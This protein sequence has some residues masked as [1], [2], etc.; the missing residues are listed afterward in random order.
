MK[1]K[2][3]NP[4]FFTLCLLLLLTVPKG[5]S[6]LTATVYPSDD[7]AVSE[8]NGNSNFGS[9]QSAIVGRVASS[10][11]DWLTF[12]RF[13][14]S[15]IPSNANVSSA[16]LHL[17]GELVGNGLTIRAYPVTGSWSESSINWNNKPSI[18]T[19]A[20]EST[21]FSSD[22]SKS[23][24]FTSF[25]STWVSGTSSNY[26]IMLL[27]ESSSTNNYVGLGTSENNTSSRRPRLVVDYTASNTAPSISGFSG[28][29][30]S[31]GRLDF[32]YTATDSDGISYVGVY[33]VNSNQSVNSSFTLA[34]E[35]QYNSGLSSGVSRTLQP[36][37]A[38]QLQ[39][40]L[41]PGTQYRLRMKAEDPQGG[42][43]GWVYSSAF[44]Y[45]ASNT[46][47]SISGFSGNMR[48]DGRLD[49][50]YTATDSDGISYV[51][52]YI[53]NNDQSV[54][55]S[56]T[57]ASEKQYNSGLSSG[58][59]RTLQPWTASQLQGWLAPGTQYRLRMKA[60]DPLGGDTG[61]VY[62]SAFT[63]TASNTA[64]S[65]SGFSGSMRSDG[66]LDFNYTATDSDGISYVGVYIVN[67]DQ[68]VN[69]SF[70]L[71]SEKQY[72]SGL[73][74][75]VARTLQP[76]TASQLQGWLTPGTQYRLRM[77]A[78]DPLGGDTGWVYSSAFTYTA[79]NTSPAITSLSDVAQL[80]DGT[81]QLQFNANDPDGDSMHA[82]LAIQRMNG[83]YVAG[84]TPETYFATV[85]SGANTLQLTPA[86][87]LNM[88]DFP[89]GQYRIR[90]RVGDATHTSVSSQNPLLTNYFSYVPPYNGGPAYNTA[91]ISDNDIESYNS[92]SA[93]EIREFLQSKGSY[94]AVSVLDVD[95]V[96][97]DAASV[98]YQA[99]QSSQINPKVLLATLEKESQGVSGSTR[100]SETRLRNL[101]GC[102]G[103]STARAQLECAAVTFRSCFDR[104]TNTGSTISGWQ[105]G[106][107]KQTQDGVEV[108]PASK[109]VA[110]QF[111]Y[112][113]YAGLQW[114][115][116]TNFGGVY[117]F[118]YFWQQF[119]FGSGVVN[120]NTPTTPIGY[121]CADYIPGSYASRGFSPFGIGHLGE[122][123]A[124]LEGT[125]IYA[126]ASGVIKYYGAATGY[127]TL[128]VAIEHDLGEETSHSFSVGHSKTVTMRNY[129]S[130]YGHLRKNSL[131]WQVG[132]E[133]Q[134]GDII[135]Y[136]QNAATNGDGNEHLHFGLFVHEYRGV[137][138]GYYNAAIPLATETHWVSGKEF[139]DAF[140]SG[141]GIVDPDV[142]QT[143]DA[144]FA[145]NRTNPKV[146]SEITHPNALASHYEAR[147]MVRRIMENFLGRSLSNTELAAISTATPFNDPSV[148][149]D[150]VLRQEVLSMLV[151]GVETIMGYERPPLSPPLTIPDIPTSG[152][153]REAILGA[154]A[155]NLADESDLSDGKIYP[156][157]PVSRYRFAKWATGTMDVLLNP[158][159]SAPT[160]DMEA[161]NLTNPPVMS[162]LSAPRRYVSHY[163][164]RLMV[165]RTVEIALGREITDPVELAMIS[166][167]TPFGDP[168]IRTGEASR[169]EVFQM[170]LGGIEGIGQ[171]SR[172]IGNGT[173]NL[174]DLPSTG[175]QL[176][177]INGC[178][179]WSIFDVTDTPSS[180]I[181]ESARVSR[182]T[183]AKWDNR[184][185]S[186]LGIS[187]ASGYDQWI[188]QE[189]LSGPDAAVDADPDR[190]GIVNL[191]E[192]ASGTLANSSASVERSTI[193]AP[194]NG[195]IDFTFR[196]LSARTDL[197]YEVELFDA[198]ET[199]KTVARS[200]AGGV[201][202][203]LD[204]VVQSINDNQ[205]ASPLVIVKIDST[206]S[207]TLLIRLRV[208]R[209]E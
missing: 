110:C 5:A 12:M 76:W 35:K 143:T 154:F 146:M 172:P 187:P 6:A 194:F 132:N 80:A 46:A 58:V 115:G 9:S 160:A 34:S 53:V 171:L 45:T 126:I 24:S 108:T 62:S 107:G 4:R 166:S 127:G 33:I 130:I 196:R 7:A 165:K 199:W 94:F 48:S 200:T 55:S 118:Y 181:Y 93:N 78:E 95:G 59:A 101:M 79:S 23:M 106:T 82:Y 175:W 136:V 28:N 52:V 11:D 8:S 40:W 148:R 207:D 174:E 57:L 68:S 49:F 81:L 61:W 195:S 14:L 77:K 177:A 1:M 121:P 124:L 21:S 47:P 205:G 37:T 17:Y 152:W 30:R 190:D 111:T 204:P 87:L 153:Q 86:I 179:A 162:D 66:R 36:W 128:V 15:S 71:A 105:V 180:E 161:L 135:G 145:L 125:P 191:I 113:P 67:N 98:I 96:M 186:I 168:S 141:S 203:L 73:S 189:G 90:V 157:A 137:V 20:Y 138:Y 144:M 119:G 56:F 83:T 176:N 122:D 103:Q 192:Y 27:S 100:P 22:G 170:F 109:A 197:N 173:I 129:C 3:V 63:Y 69:S 206:V 133:V 85:A 159:V 51:G 2:F 74:S 54:N 169:R 19:S 91:F 202:Q 44:T 150:A 70:T 117:L 116:N 147:I 163:E 114:G 64:P 42:D 193:T 97:F 201:T 142:P 184:M 123:I 88:T 102:G 183:F 10:S 164:A 50:N 139:I 155:W 25:V 99:A 32:N 167:A 149:T 29:M 140:Q 151:A 208:N 16:T 178:N 75:G 26:G 104:I 134:K 112:T 60:E 89:A 65:I 120:P 84:A 182:Y 158:P 209:A 38:S 39:S 131:S 41:T 72:N 188:A 198:T 92:M 13:D 31:D 43:T 156:E 185:L 18:A